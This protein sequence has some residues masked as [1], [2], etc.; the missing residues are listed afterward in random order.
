MHGDFFPSVNTTQ[1]FETRDT[2]VRTSCSYITCLK[3]KESRKVEI[4]LVSK[5]KEGLEGS[6]WAVKWCN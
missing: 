6:I 4:G 5:S 1:S 3:R 2:R